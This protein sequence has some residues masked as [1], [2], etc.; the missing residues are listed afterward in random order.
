MFASVL[1]PKYYVIQAPNNMYIHTQNESMYVFGHNWTPHSMTQLSL[2]YEFCAENDWEML[3]LCIPFM[4]RIFSTHLIYYQFS[5]WCKSWRVYNC[6]KMWPDLNENMFHFVFSHYLS[7]SENTIFS[8]YD[9]QQQQQQH[10][11][12]KY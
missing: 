1:H 10:L 3:L 9:E 8:C 2:F 12:L 7:I 11:M 5:V 6:C 4:Q